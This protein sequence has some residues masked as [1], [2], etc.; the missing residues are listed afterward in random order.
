MT[1][2][3]RAGALDWGIADRLGVTFYTTQNERTFTQDIAIPLVGDP[4]PP[5]SGISIDSR[6]YTDIG[7]LRHA[8]RAG[9]ACSARDT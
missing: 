7:D 5:G 6:N 9:E 4:F 2:G 1:A 3:F 8:P